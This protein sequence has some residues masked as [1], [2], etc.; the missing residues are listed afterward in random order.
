MAE[1]T[2][3]YPSPEKLSE[4]LVNLCWRIAVELRA[5]YTTVQTKLSQSDAD[6]LYL[7][8]KDKA[9]S[10]TTA[11]SA[12]KATQDGSGNV[13]SQ[14]YAKNSSLPSTMTAATSSAAGKGGTVPTPVAGANTKF[15]RG[16]G[17][18]QTALTE[19]QSLVGYAKTTDLSAYAKSSDIPTDVSELNNDAGYATTAQ[20]PTKLSDLTNDL[21]VE[22]TEISTETYSITET[23]TTPQSYAL[24]DFAHILVFVDSVLAVD[25][26]AYGITGGT[27]LQFWDVL[28]VGAEV[29][30]VKFVTSGSVRPTPTFAIDS[31]P[32]TTSMNALQNKVVTASFNALQSSFNALQSS[33]DAAYA[34]YAAEV[35]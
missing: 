31:A 2:K 35:A 3:P 19:H 4:Q 27:T 8:I 18:W 7:G 30:V 25:G 20:I 26:V 1:T 14:T 5:I 24:G 13:I 11:D 32:S 22:S 15:L 17:T 12:T 6:K 33:I 21:D 28:P 29:V 10:A 16:D 34:A 23:A 9:V